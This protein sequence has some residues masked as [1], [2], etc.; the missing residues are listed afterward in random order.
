[1]SASLEGESAARRADVA[2]VAREQL[3]IERLRS[4]QEE[5]VRQ[6]VAGRD[7]LVVMP[8]GSGK[9]AIYQLAGSLMSGTVIVV[10]PLIALQR[11]QMERLEEL[12]LGEPAAVNSTLP[13]AEMNA[14][15]QRLGEQQVKFVFVTPEQLE[16]EDVR[17]RLRDAEPA[18]VVVDEAHCISHWGHD[19]R[20]AY[21]GLGEA[22]AARG[23]PQVVALTATAAPPVRQEIVE[24]LRLRDPEV[25]VR[26][27]DRPNIWLGVETFDHERQRREALAERVLA[28]PRPGIVYAATRATAEALAARLTDRGLTAAA[29]HAGLAKRERHLIQDR[30][31]DGELGVIA[32]TVAFGMG[33]DKPDVRFVFHCGLPDSLDSYHQELGRA[34]RDGGPAEAVLFYRLQDASLS[35]F[36]GGAGSLDEPEVRKVASALAGAAGALSRERLGREAGV[37]AGRVRRIVDALGQA[38]ALELSTRGRAVWRGEDPGSATTAAMAVQERRREFQRTRLEMIQAYAELRDC[39]RRFLLNYFGEPRSEPCGRC[40][41]C[42]AGLSQR[43]QQQPF[44]LDSRVLH[45][46]WG[47]GTVVRY[48]PGKV[49]VLFDDAGYRA[50]DLQLV[51]GEAL[52]ETAAPAAE[53]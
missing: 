6:V 26:G 40:D 45:R 8:T 34:G 42:D 53:S 2:G 37:P 44:P 25:T 28:G 32:A 1:M 14:V 30:F 52:L 39:R 29:Y 10:S 27:F 47:G 4:A 21:L 9:S 48:E 19:F 7:A 41:N 33:V 46:S 22:I 3:G 35:R 24:R 20:P 23:R 38:G 12:D 5:A 36:L 13:E 43:P 31:M 15:F 18:L 11:D 51:L 50:L 16:K 17:R 49:V